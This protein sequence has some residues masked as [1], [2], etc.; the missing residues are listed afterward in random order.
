M[1]IGRKIAAGFW[2][3]LA[4]LIAVGFLSYVSMNSL[5][6][7]G[8]AVTHTEQVVTELE[9]LLST[10]KDAE[11]GQRGFIITNKSEYLAPYTMGIANAGDILQNL[12]QLTLDNPNHQRHLDKIE[13]LIALKFAELARTIQLQKERG[14]VASSAVV[15][16]DAGKTYMDQIR[17]VIAD[18]R[19]EETDIL[20][21]RT[22]AA[23]EGA[24]RT[25]YAI[26][27]GTLLAVVLVQLAGLWIARSISKP[28][29]NVVAVSQ[30]VALGDLRSVGLPAASDYEVRQL[31]DAFNRMLD[32]LK[33]LAG[34]TISVTDNLNAAA[35][36]ILASTQQQAAG[37]KQQAAT[38]QEITATMEEVRQ[39]GGQIAE[40]AKQVASAA[41]ATSA[42]S[43]S[44]LSAVEDTNRTMEDIRQQV[45]EVAENIVALSEKTQA[46]GEIIATVNDL[47]ERSNLLALNAAIEAAGAGEQG[48]RFSVVANEIKNL[49]DQAKDSTVQVRTILGEI[50][51]GINSSVMLTEEAVKRVETGKQKADVTEQT[52][53]QMAATTQESVDAFQQIIGA[54][55]QQQIGMEQLTKGMQDIRQSATQTAASTVQLEKAMVSLTAQS[56]QLR[57]AVN[58]Y[59]LA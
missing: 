21:H 39:S 20:S 27:F 56:Q 35:S 48:N 17:K 16:D 49:A 44:G 51:R 47:A 26:G 6:A 38:I 54:T 30:N 55:G 43:V 14:F 4:V 24:T 1:T 57:G 50:Q 22:A 12:R 23:E 28:L 59:Q 13:S 19:A 29:R 5:I 46:I 18:M 36:E 52:I 11:T 9:A 41:E 32:G 3:A 58:K 25:L 7:N 37:T 15:N 33:E 34:Q 31:S 8:R 45:E 10:V 40:R 2:F 53:R 42:S